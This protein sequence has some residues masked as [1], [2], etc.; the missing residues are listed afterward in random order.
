M[1]IPSFCCIIVEPSALHIS[2]APPSA[3]EKAHSFSSQ[4]KPLN[5]INCPSKLISQPQVLRVKLH[6][7]EPKDLDSLKSTFQT[8]AGCLHRVGHLSSE[9]LPPGAAAS[10]PQKL[11]PRAASAPQD[12]PWRRCRDGRSWGHPRPC[13]LRGTAGHLQVDFS[14]I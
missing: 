12:S 9:H 6:G 10:V 7:E 4:I 14:K 8:L 5:Q 2:R 1:V 13:T 3:W 11:K